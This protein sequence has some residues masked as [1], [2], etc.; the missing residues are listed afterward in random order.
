MQVILLQRIGRLGQMGDVV[1]V[2]DGYA[3]NFLLPQK[4]ALR[5][6]E[7]NRKVS[8]ASA[9]SS[10]PTISSSRRKPR[11]SPTKLE[12]Q[13]LR[14]H[15]PGRRHRPALRLGL[16][17]RYL[18]GRHRRRLHHRP[19]P[20]HPRQADQDARRSRIRSRAAP[21]S[22]R[23]GEGQRRP[24]RGRGR[25]PGPRRGRHHGQGREDR[26]RDLRPGCRVRGRRLPGR[27]RGRQGLIFG[28][29]L[30]ALT[31]TF[32]AGASQL[33]RFRFCTHMQA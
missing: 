5:A 29:S 20:G 17:A 15:S 13:E 23:Q 10:R 27:G 16:D 30:R 1:T 25:P 12:R 8:R 26:A 6:T 18:R 11:P 9:P 14:R 21:G 19:A 3:R 2:K 22:H 28:Y 7:D 24:L 4:K 31:H 33:R 32:S